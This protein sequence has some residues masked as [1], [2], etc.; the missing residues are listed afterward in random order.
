MDEIKAKIRYLKARNGHKFNIICELMRQISIK[1]LIGTRLPRIEYATFGV[2]R[3]SPDACEA[4][5]NLMVNSNL[6]CHEIPK[7][8]IMLA[9]AASFQTLIT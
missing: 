5:S 4:R 3:R 7:K 1:Q 8:S 2:G 9:L 6:I